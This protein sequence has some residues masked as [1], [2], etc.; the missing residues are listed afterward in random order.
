M[1]VGFPDAIPDQCII[2]WIMYVAFYL[3][4]VLTQFFY[5]FK[6]FIY[7]YF[8]EL[9][10]KSLKAFRL[11]TRDEFLVDLKAIWSVDIN[12]NEH[13]TYSRV[14]LMIGQ[15]SVIQSL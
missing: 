3:G 2:G 13:L 5:I 11:N 1:F 4:G 10:Q 8:I 14:L 9:N 7:S 6:A 12:F 15:L